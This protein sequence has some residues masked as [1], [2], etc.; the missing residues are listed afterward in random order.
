[1]NLKNC[2]N[3]L[4]IQQAASLT[5][6][7]QAYRDMIGIWHPD[8][9]VQ[10]PRL[11]EKATEKL[12]ELNVAYNELITRMTSGI[13]KS[14]EESN[15]SNGSETLSAFIRGGSTFVEHVPVGKYELKYAVGDIWYGTRWLFG[16]KTVF[17]KMDQVF[18]FKIQNNEIA[19]YRLDLYL[20]PA[21]L[22]DTRKDYA[23]DF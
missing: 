1:M 4:E 14:D 5:E 3:I 7:K 21:G 16:P 6:I 15:A 10:N 17:R 22:A 12:K 20:Q 9:Y 18:E 13:V 19:G 2:Y 11:H 8:R 23:F